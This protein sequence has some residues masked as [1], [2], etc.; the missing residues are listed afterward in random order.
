MC[1]SKL[2]VAK[3]RK[4]RYVKCSQFDD[5]NAKHSYEE[6]RPKNIKNR[7][8]LALYDILQDISFTLVCQLAVKQRQFKRL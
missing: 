6:D 5:G 7:L 8:I 1:S 4:V 3:H 2:P